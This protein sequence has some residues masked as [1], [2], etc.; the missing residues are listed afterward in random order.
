MHIRECFLT[1]EHLILF[2]TTE[3]LILF[4][5]TEH[6]ILFLT[7][8]HLILY[9]A[10]GQQTPSDS[11]RFFAGLQSSP[12][13]WQWWPQEPLERLSRHPL[14]SPPLLSAPKWRH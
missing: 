10:P 5:T 4:L 13:A 1:R 7:R 14:P 12:R 11:P 3:H 9:S 8:E 2:L 6:L